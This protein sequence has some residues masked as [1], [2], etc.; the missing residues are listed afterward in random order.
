MHPPDC[1]CTE[2]PGSYGCQLRRKG[3]QVPPS[4]T[5]TRTP[6][7]PWRPGPKNSWEAGIAGEHRPDG[8]FMPHLDPTDGHRLSVK[9]F[10]DNRGRYEKRLREVRA[11]LD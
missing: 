9:E 1:T 5:P 10:A 7:R 11:G 6:R 4:A 3:I 2:G 8:S